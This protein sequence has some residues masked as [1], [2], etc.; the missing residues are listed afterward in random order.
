MLRR[1]GVR[2][3]RACASYHANQALDVTPKF[4]SSC[5]GCH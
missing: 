3:T 2:G 1:G 4:K 5:F